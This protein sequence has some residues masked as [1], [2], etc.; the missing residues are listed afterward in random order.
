[1]PNELLRLKKQIA[2][3]S[4]RLKHIEERIGFLVQIT[5]PE[6]H[7]FTH[8]AL[9]ENLTRTRVDAIFSLMDEVRDS[10]MKGKPMGHSEFEERVYQI[11]PAKKGDYHFAEAI[12]R[13]L[14]SSGQY[15]DVYRHMK[16][17]GMN[18]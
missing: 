7:P 1:M 13:T 12:V 9:E 8:L 14:Y 6:R 15:V 16:T 5:D 18:I 4:S 3:L 11:V 17:D 10:M 2:E